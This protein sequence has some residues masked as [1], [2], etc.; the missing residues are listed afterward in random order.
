ME[1]TA[2]LSKMKFLRS[3]LLREE[4]ARDILAVIIERRVVCDG[5]ALRT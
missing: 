3:C 2:V 5:G 4:Y 1:M